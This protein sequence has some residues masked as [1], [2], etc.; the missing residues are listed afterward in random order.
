M[1]YISPSGEHYIFNILTRPATSTS[2]M[3]CRGR[4]RHVT[5]LLVVDVQGVEA[6]RS[7][8]LTF[9][10][11]AGL[12]IVPSSIKSIC[13]CA[14]GGSAKRLKMLSVTRL[15]PSFRRRKASISRLFLKL[16]PT[17]FR[18]RKATIRICFKRSCLIHITT[19]TSE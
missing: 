1:D 17:A 19:R 7:P 2:I 5:V 8:M 3:R 10:V 11:D 9:A 15:R 18:R 14:A 12:D 6:R 16:L 13:P 4:F